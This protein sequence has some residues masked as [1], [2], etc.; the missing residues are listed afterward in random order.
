MGVV[1]SL[2]DDWN[3]PS[4][5]I[6]RPFCNLTSNKNLTLQLA[7]SEQKVAKVVEYHFCHFSIE[8]QDDRREAYSQHSE[9]IWFETLSVTT[10]KE[11]NPDINFTSQFGSRLSSVKLFVVVIAANIRASVVLIIPFDETSAETDN[12]TT[13]P[14]ETFTWETQPSRPDSWPREII[15]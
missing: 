6:A 4:L 14:S 1:H 13:A 9:N 12:E 2:I 11:L 10:Q 5:L 3:N 8:H 7:P 15:R